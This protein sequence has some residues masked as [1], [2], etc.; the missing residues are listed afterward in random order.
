MRRQSDFAL[1]HQQSGI[2][3]FR[4]LDSLPRPNFLPAGL[5]A[6]AS[7]RQLDEKALI[8][9]RWQGGRP[10]IRQGT[11]SFGEDLP[12]TYH[13]TILLGDNFDTGWRASVGTTPL[14]H[15][16]ALGWANR[17]EVPRDAAGTLRITY[18]RWLRLLLVFGQAALV[19]M[20]LAMA[21]LRS[22]EIRG[23]LL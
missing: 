1:E 8:L 2:A 14:V 13:P 6:I 22:R 20:A 3:V 12:R 17:F 23:R 15:K 4:N 9:A 16:R 21:R 11:N 18:R 19:A 10:I 5:S 7:S